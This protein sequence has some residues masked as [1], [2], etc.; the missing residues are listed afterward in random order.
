[1]LM[2][3][4]YPHMGIDGEWARVQK[5]LDELLLLRMSR[6]LVREKKNDYH[7]QNNHASYIFLTALTPP[8]ADRSQFD[9]FRYMP[10]GLDM[11]R[12]VTAQLHA[13]GVK[14]LWPYNP[15][16]TGTRREN[17]S[18]EVRDGLVRLWSSYGR[19]FVCAR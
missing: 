4:T 9:M 8:R 14:V 15:W 18:D 3:P 19:W 17:A 16:D 13:R 12:N 2:W 10:G 1:M 7:N 5:W 6:V 11:L